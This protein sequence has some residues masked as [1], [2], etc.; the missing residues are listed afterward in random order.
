EG[1]EAR[2]LVAGTGDAA[3]YQIEEAGAEDHQAGVEKHAGLVVCVGIT[4]QKRRQGVDEQAE[5]GK[6]VRADVGQR[7]AVDNHGQQF[8]AGVSEGAGPGHEASASSCM[9]VSRRISSSRLPLGVTTVVESPTFLLSSARPMGDVV[10]ILPAATSDS[11]LVT[12][13]YSISSPL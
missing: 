12:S 3:V 8:A 13:L 1:A 5:E 2:H 11:S 7:H 9:V 10:E 6:E 4:K